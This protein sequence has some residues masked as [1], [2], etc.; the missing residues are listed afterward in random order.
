[1]LLLYP[2]PQAL[3]PNQ[4]LQWII[5]HRLPLFL[6]SDLYFEYKLC[7]IL[8]TSASSFLACYLARKGTPSHR[9]TPSSARRLRSAFRRRA[10]SRPIS[11]TKRR[12]VSVTVMSPET[13]ANV[14]GR[15][16]KRSYSANYT[17]DRTE[18]SNLVLALISKSG[19]GSFRN[20]LRG[21]PGERN[22][23]YW[24]DAEKV[25]NCHND[26]EVQRLVTMATH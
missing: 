9:D 6:K 17:S 22:M 13:H 8:I 11:S 14:S 3:S 18:P 23:L 5:Q 15:G 26:Q 25:S 24:L 7:N 4:C 21:T 16:L 10:S 19:M 20:F 2:M 1:M 12:S